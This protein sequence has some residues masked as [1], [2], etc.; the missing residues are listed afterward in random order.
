[1]NYVA[2]ICARG[3][4]KGIPDKNIR[5]LA[6]KPLIGW[7]IEVTKKVQRISDIIV[8]TDSEKIAKIAKEYGATVPFMRPKHLAED[9]SPEWSVWRHALDYLSEN[10]S[11][12]IDG[13]VVIPPTA[14]LRSVN[15]IERCINEYEKGNVDVVITVSEA[16]RNPYFN[17]VTK[18]DDG[19]VS[20]MMS[21]RS[22]VFRRQDAPGAYDVT[23]VAY[24]V[25][26]CFV[27]KYNYIF[28]GR[29]RSVE[30]PLNRSIDIDTEFDFR[31]A[32][33]LAKELVG[34]ELENDK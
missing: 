4:S 22:K 27:K 2:L 23:T 33:F 9:N 8:S 25:S 21:S 34:E 19:F 30:I 20:L 14:P 5:L 6:N 29:V 18:D 12:Q 26:P 32:E 7:A 13:L 31:I 3:G 24:V 11:M 17:M 28:E 15:D 16:H 1:M 10:K